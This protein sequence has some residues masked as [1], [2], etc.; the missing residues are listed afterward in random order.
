MRAHHAF[1]R[2][3][4]RAISLWRDAFASLRVRDGSALTL[5]LGRPADVDVVSVRALEGVRR[6][7]QARTPFVLV[8]LGIGLFTGCGQVAGAPTNGGSGSGGE[9]PDSGDGSRSLVDSSAESGNSSG[10]GSG[11]PSSPCEP[12]RSEAGGMACLYCSMDGMWHCSAGGE[13]ATLMSC[14]SDAGTVPGDCNNVGEFCFTCDEGGAGVAQM[15]SGT[16]PPRWTTTGQYSC[17][18]N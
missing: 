10:T 6:R 1:F 16:H 14:Q 17:G 12:V 15:C 11:G 9:H 7:A 13:V 8:A 2:E 4:L 18:L 3:G 5:C